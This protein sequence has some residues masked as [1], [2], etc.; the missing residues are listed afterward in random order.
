MP[1]FNVDEFRSRVSDAGGLTRNN[2]F[3]L[4]VTPPQIFTGIAPDKRTTTLQQTIS[5]AKYLEFFCYATS[6]PGLAL[7]THEY[8]RYTYGLAEKRPV[9]V[10]FRDI[11]L[12]IYFDNQRRNYDFFK[13]WIETIFTHDARNTIDDL[14]IVDYKENYASTLELFVY[15]DA[16][17]LIAKY[18]MTEAFPIAIGDM[19][20]NWADTNNLLKIPVTFTFYTMYNEFSWLESEYYDRLTLP[21]SKEESLEKQSQVDGID[22]GIRGSP[23]YPP[24]GSGIGKYSLP[25]DD[26]VTGIRD[27]NSIDGK[28]PGKDPR[29]IVR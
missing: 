26:V 4:V 25:P 3:R 14:F 24:Y 12:S 21:S 13:S 19:P 16:G 2:K 15:N 10:Q 11:T 9:A 29:F 17:I 28:M 20:V 8:R 1:G 18:V 27:K 7:N 6:I 23:N 22:F 5:H